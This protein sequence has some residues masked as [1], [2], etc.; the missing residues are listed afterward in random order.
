MQRCTLTIH[1][2]N[3]GRLRDLAKDSG[4]YTSHSAGLGSCLG[5]K[6]SISTQQQRNHHRHHWEAPLPW[7]STP[8]QLRPW[9]T[10]CVVRCCTNKDNLG[11]LG[12]AHL[13]S[14]YWGGGVGKIRSS[15]S[16]STT[17]WDPGQPELDGTYIK[18]QP[19]NLS[20]SLSK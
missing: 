3:H 14:Q 7:I 11:Q 8:L 20:F 2:S 18:Q 19:Q 16:S 4:P 9:K 1:L 6:A 10:M 13:E 17:W 12:N 15:M 5:N